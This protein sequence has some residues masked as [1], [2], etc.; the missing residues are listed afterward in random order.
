MESRGWIEEESDEEIHERDPEEDPEGDSEE[1][2][3][4]EISIRE[5]VDEPHPIRG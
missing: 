1:E 4:E 3:D 2:P 5:I